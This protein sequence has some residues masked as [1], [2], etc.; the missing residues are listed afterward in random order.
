MAKRRIDGG[1]MQPRGRNTIMGDAA[2]NLEPGDNTKYIQIGM[3]LMTMEPIDLDN[4][5]EV[6]KRIGEFFETYARYDTKPTV[7]GLAMALGFDRH[8]L[9]GIVNEVPTH[10]YTE[11]RK[12]APECRAAIKKSYNFMEQLWEIFMQNGKIN[13]V[14][15]IFL[16]KNQF[17]YVDKVEHVVTPNVKSENDFSEEDIRQRYMIEGGDGDG[18]GS[19]ASDS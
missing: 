17:G 3:E 2:L 15:G 12:I 13:P 6:Q 14:A 9:W 1:K 8:E 4:V 10:G 5:G 16:G 18:D 11:C 19:T 7:A